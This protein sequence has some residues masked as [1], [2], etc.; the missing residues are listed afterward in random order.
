MAWGWQRD[1]KEE[2]TQKEATEMEQY[3][4]LRK[5]LDGPRISLIFPQNYTFSRC[6]FCDGLGV[7]ESAREPRIPNHHKNEKD[8]VVL[9]TGNLANPGG[10]YLKFKMFAKAGL[11]DYGSEKIDPN[12]GKDILIAD[13]GP[14]G[15]KVEDGKLTQCDSSIRILREGKKLFLE[16]LILFDKKGPWW[17]NKTKY[18]TRIF[19]PRWKT[20]ATVDYPEW[21]SALA[22]SSTTF[23]PRF[24]YT[25]EVK[26]KTV[27]GEELG[28][29]F[30]LNSANEKI[31]TGYR[32]PNRR[33]DFPQFNPSYNSEILVQMNPN[34]LNLFDFACT[35]T[36]TACLYPIS[37]HQSGGNSS[38]FGGSTTYSA[39]MY[40]PA[41]GSNGLRF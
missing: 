3:L 35:V 4:T 19:D 15:Y 34:H 22:E 13:S 29:L 41:C 9:S 31:A 39:R 11:N 12:H 16:G 33:K 17:E 18:V 24:K 7:I 20:Y 28:V 8:M 32:I 2:R 10:L 38:G 14:G 36:T 6:L 23:H 37:S 26:E 25:P 40:T 1:K 5:I 30:W 27:I 21:S